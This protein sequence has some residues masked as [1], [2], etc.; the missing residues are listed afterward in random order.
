MKALRRRPANATG[1][2][3]GDA[4]RHHAHLDGLPRG[5]ARRVPSSAPRRAPAPRRS[6][7]P[8]APPPPDEQSIAV[9]PLKMLD[10]GRGC[11]K[12]ATTPTSAS[13]LADALITRLGS[14]RRFALRPTSSVLR[15]GEA[16][17]DP[18]DAGRQ[19]AVGYVLDG[20]IRHAGDRIRVNVQLLD[21]GAGS[22]V[23]AGQ[24]DQKFTDVLAL[25][26]AISEQVAEAL[27]PQ[28]TGGERLRLQKRAPT[29]PSHE[30]YCGGATTEHLTEG[31]SPCPHPLP[32]AVA[33]TRTT[34]SL[35][36]IADYFTAR[37]L[38]RPALPEPRP[39][40]RRRARSRLLRPGARR[41]PL[42]SLRLLTTT[43]SGP[44]KGSPARA[45]VNPTTDG[46]LWYG[47]R[48]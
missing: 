24:F 15:F 22:A 39:P 25:E 9:L 43:S 45:G 28:L 33:R 29:P 13:G 47:Y 48:S 12:R 26:D 10:T 2:V 19:L 23:W 31:A 40:P 35:R 16:D 32:L 14:L 37:R 1:L 7:E 21:V 42:R 4:R 38:L 36:R 20:R 3:P 46:A 27:V 41:G 5:P 18:F 30:A 34:R 8:A 44:R 11:D 6:R 17:T